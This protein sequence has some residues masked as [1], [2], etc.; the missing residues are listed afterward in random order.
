V[1]KYPSSE[2]SQA[3]AGDLEP[4]V[5]TPSP[6]LTSVQSDEMISLQQLD[7]STDWEIEPPTPTPTLTPSALDPGSVTVTAPVTTR[8]PT[9]SPSTTAAPSPLLSIDPVQLAV[10]KALLAMQTSFAEQFKKAE[11]ERERDRERQAE[12]TRQLRQTLTDVL[13]QVPKQ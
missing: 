10:Q 1:R 9:T 5:L 4:L 3:N 13:A 11:A 7:R 8:Q 6:E 12:E 2:L